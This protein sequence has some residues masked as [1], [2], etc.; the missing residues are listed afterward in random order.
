MQNK[1]G[2]L[3]RPGC[4]AENELGPTCEP[5]RVDPPEKED[6]KVW[7]V[8]KIEYFLKFECFT[9]LKKRKRKKGNKKG[10]INKKERERINMKRKRR[11][12]T[13]IGR[14]LYPARGV[15]HAIQ[16]YLVG[17]LDLPAVASMI[18]VA[19]PCCFGRVMEHPD[20]PPRTLDGARVVVATTPRAQSHA[21]SQPQRPASPPPREGE[22]GPAS[23]DAARPSSDSTCLRRQGRGSEARF[24]MRRGGRLGLCFPK[25][26]FMSIWHAIDI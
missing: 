9:N 12:K 14:A 19:S 16:T 22:E 11:K 4:E 21:P 15:R 23:T 13:E 3:A 25:N 17:V 10:K 18:T 5:G 2:P 1:K 20:Q 24:G 8:F 6:F 7:T 26:I